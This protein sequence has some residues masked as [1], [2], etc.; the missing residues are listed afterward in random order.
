MAVA[1]KSQYVRGQAVKEEAVM[2][3]D[4]GATGEAFKRFFKS[5]QRFDIQ[6]IGRFIEQK[7]VSAFFQHLCHVHAVAFTAGQ[8][9]N[10]F[11]LVRALKIERPD[12]G[13]GWRFM[14]AQLHKVRAA[15]DFLPHIFVGVQI[16]AALVDEAKFHGFADFHFTGIRHFLTS[17][18]AEKC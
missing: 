17:D 2:A 5:R 16:I 18:Q 7:H 12:I 13:A 9:T 14:L 3:D 4:H 11:L 6:I 15:G 10:L 8:Q 1:F